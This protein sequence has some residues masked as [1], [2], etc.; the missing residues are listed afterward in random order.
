MTVS[1]MG[2]IVLL[3]KSCDRFFAFAFAFGSSW[4]PR[5]VARLLLDLHAVDVGCV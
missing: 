1:K 5:L 3:V 2:D 4:F